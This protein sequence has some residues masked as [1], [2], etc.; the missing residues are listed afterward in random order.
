MFDRLNFW[1]IG[2]KRETQ[3]TGKAAEGSRGE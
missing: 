2:T 3:Q 1:S